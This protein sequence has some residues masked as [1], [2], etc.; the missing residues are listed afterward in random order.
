MNAQC[1][2]NAT[3]SYSKNYTSLNSKDK[4]LQNKVGQA[5]GKLPTTR[6]KGNNAANQ[7]KNVTTNNT[8]SNQEHGLVQLTMQRVPGKINDKVRKAM[9]RQLMR[10]LLENYAKAEDNTAIK[11]KDM[12]E[13]FSCIEFNICS[14]ATN[15]HHYKQNM[16]KLFTS[17]RNSTKNNVIHDSLQ[18][19]ISG[20][21]ESSCMTDKS[22]DRNEKFGQCPNKHNDLDVQKICTKF[23]KFNENQRNC[24][25]YIVKNS[26]LNFYQYGS[27]V[28]LIIRDVE[29]QECSDEMSEMSINSKE[30][31]V[32]QHKSQDPI[33]IEISSGDE[34]EELRNKKSEH[35]QSNIEKTLNRDVSMN[36]QGGASNTLNETIVI[37]DDDE[38]EVVLDNTRNQ[39]MEKPKGCDSEKIGIE[40]GRKKSLI[41]E[42][43]S[44]KPK[45]CVSIDLEI[46]DRT[47]TIIKKYMKQY[48]QSRVI[49]DKAMLNAIIQQLH[50]FILKKELYDKE[51]I[52][53][54]IDNFVKNHKFTVKRK[55]GT[56]ISSR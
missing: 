41:V 7:V 9:G 18:E 12:Y 11:E 15:I 31:T 46:Q 21:N 13:L 32:L 39:K 26:E 48:Y 23:S 45:V 19:L 30:G 27:D 10:A 52:K 16:H 51:S 40:K 43:T 3:C 34:N 54:V 42:P 28:A 38:I 33:I 49:P 53:G 2:M 17:V 56:W 20:I 55:A 1:L 22:V 29:D 37:E 44:A 14:N 47:A 35:N 25:K 4:S 24:D 50:V 36:V 6:T 8:Y 5:V